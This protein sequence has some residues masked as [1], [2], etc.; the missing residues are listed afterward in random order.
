MSKKY[1]NYSLNLTSEEKIKYLKFAIESGNKKALK[2]LQNYYYNLGNE[3]TGKDA[4]EW[5]KLAADLDH[6]DS[7][8]KLGEIYYDG[9]IVDKSLD[10]SA[11]YYKL[12]LK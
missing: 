8:Y 6:Y 12:A 5:Y 1:Y 7:Q 10:E 2:E 3:A 11:K 4:I 9:E